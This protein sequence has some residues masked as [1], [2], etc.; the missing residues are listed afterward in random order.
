[1]NS[2]SGCGTCGSV[3]QSCVLEIMNDV[4]ACASSSRAVTNN[5]GQWN[6]MSFKKNVTFCDMWKHADL[7]T[8]G[9]FVRNR[10]TFTKLASDVSCRFG[11]SMPIP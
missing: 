10:N 1:M 4:R 6:M 11:K 9:R 8:L 5:S 7:R 3:V 2:V